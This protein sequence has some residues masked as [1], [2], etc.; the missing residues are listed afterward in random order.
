MNEIE[1]VVWVSPFLGNILNLK[2]AVW[3]DKLGLY[4]R[5]IVTNDFSIG[6]MISDLTTVASAVT[7]PNRAAVK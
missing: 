3:W 6:K 7:I 1:V 5:K 4:W 2:E